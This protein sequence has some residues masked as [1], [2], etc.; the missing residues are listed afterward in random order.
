MARLVYRRI[1]NRESIVGVH[2]V[3]TSAGGGG[4]RWYEFRVGEN[5]KVSLYQ[6][7]TYAPDSLYRWMASPAMDRL[8]NIGIGYSF[9]GRPH[10]A[11]Q[12]FAARLANDQPGTLTLREAVLVEG[13]APQ[14]AM[15]WQDYTQTAIDPS[16]DC[17]IWYLGDYVKKGETAYSSRI[18]AFRLP[19]CQGTR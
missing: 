3:N 12:R 17:T 9:G 1:G 6:Q 16:D 8:G 11:G 19:G 5:R 4:V 2:S 13:E 18:G 10:F 7:G 14:A 15:R